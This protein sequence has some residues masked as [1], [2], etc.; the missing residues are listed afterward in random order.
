MSSSSSF[1][2]LARETVFAPYSDLVPEVIVQHHVHCNKTVT[3]YMDIY[4][5][6]QKDYCTPFRMWPLFN[7]IFVNFDVFALI[8]FLI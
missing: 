6:D 4:L 1:Q 2:L 3:E 7:F 8:K 5:K